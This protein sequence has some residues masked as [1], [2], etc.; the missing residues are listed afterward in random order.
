MI[1]LDN[2]A[3]TRPYEDVLQ[4]YTT[5]ARN[6]FG[7]P[8]SLHTLGMESENVLVQAKKRLG[9]FL[10]CAT[11]QIVLTSGGTEANALAIHGSV[12]RKPGAHIITT[13]VEHASI[14]E[15]MQL[16]EQNGYDVTYLQADK[17]G[18]IT[19]EQVKKAMQSNTAL[20]SICHVQGELGTIQPI[21]EIGDF[22]QHYPQ[23][24]YH[25]DAV[26][27]LLKV[28]FSINHAKVDL[29]SLSSHKIHG[30]KGTGMLYVRN[31]KSIDSLYRGGEQEQLIRPGTEHVAGAA[32]FAKALGI[33]AKKLETEPVRL[34]NLQKRLFLELKDVDGIR[35]NS[36]LEN[37]APHIVNFSIAGLKAEVLVQSL[38]QKNIY[39]STQSACS[40]KSGKPSRILL[41]ADLSKEI[42]ESAIRI[43]LSFETMEE[44]IE[45]CI[46]AIKSIVPKL[47][48]VKSG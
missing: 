14:Y 7:N 8:S 18:F 24:K 4:V 2:S 5:I 30:T 10:H 35:I 45:T 39:V 41:G 37:V 43:S 9:A 3:T 42:A 22:L 27:S 33:G 47:Q 46:Q 16:L 25:V 44:E 15:N 31:A 1:Y 21:D 29:L 28:P 38:A 36:P 13:T 26:Q 40:V 34:G 17:Y 6:Y 20:V 23:V 11:D 19:V 32:G 12:K 48:E